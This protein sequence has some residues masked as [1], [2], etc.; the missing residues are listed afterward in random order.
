LA[1]ELIDIVD[2]NNNPLGITKMKYEAFKDGLWHRASHIWIYNSKGQLLLQLRSKSKKIYA[3]QWD[4]SAAGHI[5]AGEDPVMTA[6]RETKE[7]LGLSIESKDLEFVKIV[8]CHKEG[9]GIIE[10]EFQYAY[11][12]KFD[13]NKK[14]LTLQKEEVQEI[15]FFDLDWLEQDLVSNKEKYSDRGSYWPEMIEEIRERMA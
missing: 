1:D 15:R 11:L 14:A 6:L 8:K 10:N 12:L 5:G 7:E 4:I 13:V 9:D 3:N 2:E